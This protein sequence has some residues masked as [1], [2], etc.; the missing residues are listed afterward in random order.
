MTRL[1]ILPITLAEMWGKQAPSYFANRDEVD[2]DLYEGL[3][4]S[5][6]QK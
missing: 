3:I 5:A 2:N 4:G 1:K 6:Y